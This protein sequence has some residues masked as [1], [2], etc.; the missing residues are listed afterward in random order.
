V[1]AL[2]TDDRPDETSRAIEGP[3]DSF[4]RESGVVADDQTLADADQ[5]GSDR[6]QAASDRDQTAS[7]RDQTLADADQLASDRDFADGGE[8]RVHELSRDLRDRGAA[9]R[10][11]SARARIASASIRDAAAHAR[12]MAALARDQVAAL[13]DRE[14]AALDASRAADDVRAVSG[15]ES[16]L[17]AAEQ[18][19]RA[20]ADRG[21]A[22][23][24][25]ARAAADREHAA[26]DRDQAA[27]D[28]EQAQTDREVI[29]ASLALGEID[30]LTGARTRAAGLAHLEHE[31]E[32]ERRTGLLSV[33]YVTVMGRD[34]LGDDDV[35]PAGDALLKSAVALIREHLRSYDLIVAL[36]GDEFLCA[37]SSMTL[38]EARERF[39]EVAAALT[40]TSGA[41]AIR[42]GFAQATPSENATKLLSRAHRE[43]IDDA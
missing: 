30:P 21:S 5:T 29:L 17:R 6:D 27:G 19:R 9:E 37:M 11:Q 42:T 28:G 20:A 24:S 16:V 12:D 10:R 2:P 31:V 23:E 43:L 33:A 36:G 34:T 39:S 13:H 40:A 35:R 22:A 18:R 8:A 14:S 38:G 41:L 3:Q 15:T 4:V 26:R 25:R 32:R 1:A 7:D